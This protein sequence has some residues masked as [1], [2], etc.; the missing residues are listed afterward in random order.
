MFSVGGIRS[1]YF[2]IGSLY[3]STSM[4]SCFGRYENTSYMP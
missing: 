3:L 1:V 2:V 4:R